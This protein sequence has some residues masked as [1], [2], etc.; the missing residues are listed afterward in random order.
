MKKTLELEQKNEL[1]ADKGEIIDG[2]RAECQERRETERYTKHRIGE[3][4]IFVIHVLSFGGFLA[5]F[6]K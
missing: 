6:L 4:A 2:L 3:C 1:L 5:N